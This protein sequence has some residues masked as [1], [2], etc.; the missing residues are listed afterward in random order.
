MKF[1]TFEI[2]KRCTVDPS[3]NYLHD[4][5]DRRLVWREQNSPSSASGQKKYVW[6]LP[7]EMMKFTADISCTQRKRGICINSTESIQLISV[8][9]ETKLITHDDIVSEIVRVGIV[10]S[11]WMHLLLSKRFPRQRE[12]RELREIE[13]RGGLL[14]AIADER[15][16]RAC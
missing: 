11:A 13:R 7:H 12:R 6:M 1:R 10:S 8:Q 4:L 15:K 3:I 16:E 5:S 2:C 9:R 14:F